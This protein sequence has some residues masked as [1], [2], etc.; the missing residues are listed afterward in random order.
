MSKVIF[1]QTLSLLFAVFLAMSVLVFCPMKASAAGETMDSAIS[2]Q[3]NTSNPTKDVYYT[4]TW[5]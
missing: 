5:S 3:L 1:R 4:K 2:I